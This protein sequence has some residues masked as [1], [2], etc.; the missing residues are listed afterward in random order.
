MQKESPYEYYENK[1]GVQGRFLFSGKNAHP[2]SL[3]L[4]GER[5]FQRRIE[6]EQIIRIRPQAPNTPMLVSFD[7][8]PHKWQAAIVNIWGKAEK[9]ALQTLFEKYYIRDM[10]A[11]YFYSTYKFEDQFGLD[12]DKI[13]EYTINAS[14]LNTCGKIYSLRRKLRKEM[15]GE[16]RPIWTIINTECKRFKEVVGHDLPDN[17]RRLRDKYNGYQKE[18]YGFLIHKGHRQVNALKVDDEHLDLLNNMFGKMEH[19]P[20]YAEVAQTYDGFL[21]GY[22]QVINETTGEVYNPKDFKKLS[23]ATVYNHLSKWENKIGNY[24]ARSGD[25]QRY[26]AMFKPYH[27]LLQPQFAG[28]IISVDDR[29]PV[30]EYEDGK[31][32][33]FYNGIDLGSEAFTCW[34]YGTSKKGI[35]QEFY[36]QMVRNYAMWGLSLPAELEGELNLNASFT[37]TF[38]KEG[39]MFQFVRIEANNARGK[40]IEQYYRPLRY[41][42]EKKREGWLAR[43]FA[44]NESNQARTDKKTIVPFDEIVKG[45]LNDIQSWNNTEHSKIKGL[46]RWDVFLAMQNPNLR[47]INYH[48]ILPYL[49][50]K[51]ESSV[52]TGIVR[53]RNDKFLLGMDGVICTGDK[54]IKMMQQVEGRNVNI[55]W[56]DDNFG[57]VL[58][59]HIYIDGRFVCEA[60]PQPGYQRARIE[61]TKED[62]LNRE[63]MSKYVNTIESFGRRQ[64]NELDKLTI[65]DNRPVTIGNSFKIVDPNGYSPAGYVPNPNPAK[66]LESVND[67]PENGIV[68]NNNQTSFKRSLLNTF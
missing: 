8:L 57:A 33:W 45:C 13:D 46:S 42:Y 1:L 60:I 50:F 24:L 66:V 49:G 36:R 61:Q 3:C 44:L 17:E 32:M 37:D 11:F 19:K 27:K 65:I 55:Y 41:Q 5:G 7:S 38:L 26:M 51:E 56:L 10:D 20:T 22:V 35:I 34:V 29:N 40:R 4:I 9:Q 23:P 12:R 18:G 31:R 58:K 15:K 16:V 43:P 68:L 59:A 25:R 30:F 14:V 53:F 2:D 21:A 67:E 62:L 64:K 47:P 63:L 28:S 48:G 39:N 52:N 6:R 54:L